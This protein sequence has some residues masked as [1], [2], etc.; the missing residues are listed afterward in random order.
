MV[1]SI[2][3]L[4]H[5][6]S[7]SDIT[8]PI[9]AIRN[10]LNVAV[11]FFLAISGYFLA[12]KQLD[13]GG[14][15]KF[16]KR[17]VPRVYIPV[18][19]CSLA[20]LYVDLKHGSFVGPFFKFFSCGYS[21]YYFVAVIIQ[22]Y[23]LLWILQKYVSTKMIFFFFVIGCIWWTFNTFFVGMYMG[24]S[25]P[26]IVNAGNII[27]W[28]LFFILGMSF[29]RDP[30]LYNRISYKVILLG[31]IVFMVL[32]VFESYIIMDNTQSL[33]GLGQKLSAFCLNACLC[34]LALHNTS[35]SIVS[36]YDR[37]WFV[38]LM[39]LVG[40]YSFGIYLIHL[41]VLGFIC[42]VWN[43][44]SVPSILW[45]V[46]SAS[47]VLACLLFLSVCKKLFPKISW[48]LLGV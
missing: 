31:V 25:L 17:H 5:S 29:S 47:V 12:K 26:L 1:V 33:K 24:K 23:L 4:G 13:N 42:S 11:P 32:S 35:K 44:I 48:V 15:L 39:C 46:C 8:L 2:H 6:Y 45:I 10:L 20:Y 16:L 9:I 34:V 18:L 30:D 38:Q 19:F 41:F 7:Y 22:C 3:C 14:Y 28:G 37:N 21:I 43:F 27:P 36:R 40:R